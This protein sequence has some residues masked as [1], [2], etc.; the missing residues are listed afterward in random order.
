MRY[1]Q[2]YIRLFIVRYSQNCPKTGYVS[3]VNI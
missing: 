3:S 1:G 2:E